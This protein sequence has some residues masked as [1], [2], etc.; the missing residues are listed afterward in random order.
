MFIMPT[1]TRPKRWRQF[2]ALAVAGL[3]ANSAHATIPVN[4]N[5]LTL[6]NNVPGNVVITPSVEF[7]TV[8]SMANIG[9]FNPDQ[10]YGG[11]FDADKCY[12]YDPHGQFPTDTPAAQ[13]AEPRGMVG[14]FVPRSWAKSSPASCNKLW[15]GN[16]L[17]W[18]GTQTIDTFRSVMT[19]GFRIVDEPDRTV[20]EKARHTGQTNTGYGLIGGDKHLVQNETPANQQFFATRLL[21]LG[22]KMYFVAADSNAYSPKPGVN[23]SLQTLLDNPALSASWGAR[24]SINGVEAYT[25]QKIEPF[26]VYAINLDVLVC[27]PGLLEQNCTRYQ[28]QYK[29][30]GLI[31]KYANIFTYSV[32]GY[33]N[34]PNQLQDGAALRAAQKFVGP[35]TVDPVTGLHSNPRREWDPATGVFI[36]NPNPEDANSTSASIGASIKDSGVINYINKFGQ[37]TTAGDKTY[38]SVG[39]MYYAAVRYLKNQRPV[40][41]Y[42]DMTTYSNDLPYIKADGFPVITRW[43]DPMKYTCQKNFI[44]GIGDTNTWNDKNLPGNL[45]NHSNE[46]PTPPEVLADH[47]VDVSKATNQIAK[48][49]GIQI[50]TPFTG[51]GNSAFMAG[52]AFDSHTRDIRPDLAGDQFV[53]TF[54]VDVAEYQRLQGMA[55]N[56]YQLTAKYGGFRVP[57]RFDPY[58]FTGPMP[59]S[60]W[61]STGDTIQTT[62]GQQ[63]RPDNFFEGGN[64][65]AMRKGFSQAF[66][67]IESQNVGSQ[68]SLSLNSSLLTRN[69][70]VYQASYQE[71]RWSGSLKAYAINPTTKS[72]NNT[73][74][75]DAANAMPP[76][77][78]RRIYTVVKGK[79]VPF[80]NAH[81]TGNGW[82]PQIVDY[83][84]G[85]TS[86]ETRNGGALRDRGTTLGDVVN[87]QPIYVG[88]PDATKFAGQTF[89]GSNKYAQF[90]SDSSASD[91]RAVVY[92][93][94]NDGMLHSFDAA[95][96]VERYAFMPGSLLEA[97]Y[98]PALLA[99]PNYGSSLNPHRYFNDGQITVAD[100]YFRGQWHTVLVGTTGRG[101][102]MAVYA[103]DVTDPDNVQLL[104]E[105]NADNSP[106]LGQITGRPIVTQTASGWEVIF[107]NGYNSRTGSSALLSVALDGRKNPKVEVIVAGSGPDNGLSTPTILID[108]PSAGLATTAYAGDIQGNI[109][110]FDLDGKHSGAQLVFK[111]Q[112]DASGVHQPV[113][114]AL[115]LG[116]D[117][118]SGHLWAFFGTGRYLG[119][120]DLSNHQT[121]SWY[122]LI[123]DQ[124]LPVLQS[125]LV[126]RSILSETAGVQGDPNAKP[127]VV[128]VNPARTLSLGTLGDMEGKSGW[129][130]NLTSPVNGTE[131]ER[132]TLGNQFNNQL[133]IGATQIPDTHD[134]CAP[135][136]RGWIMAV[137]P[138]TGTNPTGAFFDLNNDGAVDSQDL[139]HFQGKATPAGGIGFAS[140]TGSP[141]FSGSVMMVNQNGTLQSRQVSPPA[142][143]NQVR[144]SWR[145]IVNQRGE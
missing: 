32:F 106:Y 38:D 116:K 92:L 77:G 6:S 8:M 144:I 14:Y 42:S 4:Q 127:P 107:G 26:H 28:S 27:Q 142:A 145:E 41:S 34:I 115:L 15:S 91:R 66:A 55:T 12:D 11:Y 64:A 75:W 22:N 3:V 10:T 98:T 79:Y 50:S 72:I 83:L 13:T 68:S 76:F 30:E 85:D 62:A 137:N 141:A 49:D 51:L 103:L 74:L 104:W 56:Q 65:I 61:S 71:G 39:E 73:P 33:L 99:Q 24:N 126:Q 52:L 20:L 5:P 1:K 87:S 35:N 100:A 94:A 81:V 118:N 89:T 54:W 143:A 29:P 48:I 132:M 130:M 112:A 90:A 47:S 60:W 45:G 40:A 135:G 46:P 101:E 139:I 124:D 16:F 109:W 119:T 57:S 23:L 128:P 80:D 96:G 69:S 95:T 82:T 78:Q 97:Q 110:K 102:T 21:G 19:G 120:L 9:A 138:F 113:T 36:R 44:L 58:S 114:S 88:K 136:G 93:A 70:T 125:N 25:G 123:L 63:A 7:P 129:F 84:L 2:T 53:S 122:G 140:Q 108:P 111:T 86:H 37:M 131:G 31:Q 59:Q 67:L 17:N 134:P 133:L 121:Q 117:L 105:I 18:A 43:Q